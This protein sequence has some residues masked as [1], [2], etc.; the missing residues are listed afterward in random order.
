MINFRTRIRRF[1]ERRGYTYGRNPMR[2]FFLDHDF[3]TVL[4]VGANRGQYATEL[5]EYWSYENKIVSF[6]PMSQAYSMLCEQ[7]QGDDRW[8]GKNW[9]LGESKTE[10]TINIAGNSASSS[11][12]GMTKAHTDVLPHSEYVGKETIE[13]RALDDEFADLVPQGDKVLLKV[14]TQGYELEVLKGATQSLKHIAA[15]QLEISLSPLYDGAPLVEDVVGHARQAGF[16]PYWFLPG[17]W[18]TKT[19]QQLQIEGLFV[20]EDFAKTLGLDNQ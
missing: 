16:V 20:R 2:R 1:M 13:V 17:F 4:D 10:Q 7:M 18:N 5:R 14:D 9:A 15:L 8:Q 12:L 19:H 3:D 6:E 11:L